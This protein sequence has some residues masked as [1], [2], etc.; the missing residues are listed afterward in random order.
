MGDTTRVF[1]PSSDQVAFPGRKSGRSSAGGLPSSQSL[2][3]QRC[4]VSC[5]TCRSFVVG[6]DSCMGSINQSHETRELSASQPQKTMRNSLLAPLC[7]TSRLRR[8]DE[9]VLF[10][11][12]NR[13]GAASSGSRAPVVPDPISCWWKRKVTP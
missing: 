10:A 11:R 12:P 9:G 7:G 8:L 6:A 4:S 2:V 5:S 3:R 1:P 13:S